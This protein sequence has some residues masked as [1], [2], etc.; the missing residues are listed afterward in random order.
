M[1]VSYH[2]AQY[3]NIISDLRSEIHRLKKK[4]DAQR[5]Q[6]TKNEKADIRNVQGE[7]FKLK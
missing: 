4:I 5:I 6:Q 3:T 1:N 7:W 2:I